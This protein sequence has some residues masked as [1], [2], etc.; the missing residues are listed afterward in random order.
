MDGVVFPCGY[1]LNNDGDGLNLYYGAADTSV[2]L[3]RG[4]ASELLAWLKRHGRPGGQGP[5]T[6]V[7]N[8][9]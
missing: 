6:W 7:A 1:T 2:C 3:A 4:R 5:D 9:D 8:L